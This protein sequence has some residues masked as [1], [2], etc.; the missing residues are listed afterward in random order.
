MQDGREMDPSPQSRSLGSLFAALSRQLSTLFRRELALARAELSE[1]VREAGSGLALLAA[2]GMI[3]LIGLFFIVQAVVF[4][5]VALLDLWLPAEIAV[6][7]GP[8]LVGLAAVLV[9]WAL[10]SSGRGKLSAETLAMQRTAD[11]LRK[12]T[13]LA[14]EHLSNE[15]R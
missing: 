1:K 9:G 8:L 7:L 2:G 11:S 13:A 3:I 14:K 12:D 6:W 15:P 5:I 4:G 10:L